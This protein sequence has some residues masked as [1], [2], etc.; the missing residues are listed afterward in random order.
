M[1]T[2][3]RY[4][5]TVHVRLLGVLQRYRHKE[6][7]VLDPA[8]PMPKRGGTKRVYRY[9]PTTAWEKAVIFRA[10]TT[11]TIPANLVVAELVQRFKTGKASCR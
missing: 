8:K 5:S 9:G 2:P 11:E 1:A 10:T 4:R 7:Y 6:G 3:G